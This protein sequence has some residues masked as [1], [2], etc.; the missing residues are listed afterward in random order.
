MTLEVRGAILNPMF[1]R[2]QILK[3]LHVVHLLTLNC[4]SVAKK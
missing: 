4:I 1:T 2:E 3:I